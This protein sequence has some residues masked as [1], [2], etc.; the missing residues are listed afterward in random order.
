MSGVFMLLLTVAGLLYSF[1]NPG[2]PNVTIIIE[3]NAGRHGLLLATLLLAKLSLSP[4]FSD[5]TIWTRVPV[6]YCGC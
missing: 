2:F 6:L 5:P 3:R 1:A 4:R